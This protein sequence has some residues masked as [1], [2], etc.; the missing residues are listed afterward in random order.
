MSHQG[1]I[2]LKVMAKSGFFAIIQTVQIFF[3]IVYLRYGFKET[4]LLPVYG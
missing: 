2:T 1:L 3:S 4:V